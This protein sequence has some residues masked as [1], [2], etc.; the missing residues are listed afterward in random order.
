MFVGTVRKPHCWFSHGAAHFAYLLTELT[1]SDDSGNKHMSPDARK[2]GLQ[3]FRPGLTQ[4]GMYSH[5][6]RLEA[7]NFGF[8]KKGDCTIRVAKTKALSSFAVTAKLICAFVF[9]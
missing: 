3:G 6:S 5:R 8:K 2:T 7:C 4:I 1:V 9:A